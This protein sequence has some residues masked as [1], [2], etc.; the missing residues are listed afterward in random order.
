MR[1]PPAFAVAVIAVLAYGVLLL[2]FAVASGVG[3][4]GGAA[5]P[6][7]GV[8]LSSLWEEAMDGLDCVNE[9]TVLSAL[10]VR[11]DRG[12][13]ETV[14]LRF[15]GR[16]RD[17][18]PMGYA[19]EW[20]QEEGMGT[21]L[22]PAAVPPAAGLHPL[23]LLGALDRLDPGALPGNGS[24]LIK[25]RPECR[26]VV[27]ERDIALLENGSLQALAYAAF[28]AEVPICPVTFQR[29][30]DARPI[31]TAFLR[32]DLSKTGAYAFPGGAGHA[33]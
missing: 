13:P 9:T 8:S 23:R 25:V 33:T 22:S 31:L 20:R 29:R 16:D 7:P 4:S 15:L 27:Y 30:G 1:R 28:T 14:T 2:L 3:P 21:S 19:V 18:T 17:G 26:D 32:E 12:V 10:E 6:P 11:M 24:L 5:S